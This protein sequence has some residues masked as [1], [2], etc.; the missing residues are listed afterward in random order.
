[1]LRQTFIDGEDNASLRCVGCVLHA[2]DLRSAGTAA[3]RHSLVDDSVAWL[4]LT[5]RGR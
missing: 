5:D 4:I 3:A 2:K 1:M